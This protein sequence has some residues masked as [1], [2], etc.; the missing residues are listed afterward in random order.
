MDDVAISQCKVQRNPFLRK[1]LVF[2]KCGQW[3]AQRVQPSALFNCL[4]RML[5]VW[6]D[7]S[8]WPGGGFVRVALWKMPT[9]FRIVRFYYYTKSVSPYRMWDRMLRN[10]MFGY[11]IK[12]NCVHINDYSFLP[13]LWA[14]A[15]RIRNS[16]CNQKYSL[17]NWKWPNHDIIHQIHHIA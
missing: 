9:D 2:L 16:I 14:V 17:C 13:S 15:S 4:V 8:Q 11:A 12:I 6:I 10:Y 1:N 7:G 5:H 3:V